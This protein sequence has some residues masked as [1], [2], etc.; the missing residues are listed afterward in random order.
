VKQEEIL[1]FL[2][3]RVHSDPQSIDPLY[4]R[5]QCVVCSFPQI[6]GP[7]PCVSFSRNPTIYG[8]T[9]SHIFIM[10]ADVEKDYAQDELVKVPVSS[11][12]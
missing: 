9:F 1:L 6:S 5:A 7:P 2:S 4:G 10:E 12:K 3:V 8:S 11:S